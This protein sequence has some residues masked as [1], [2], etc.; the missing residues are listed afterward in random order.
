MMG[1][2]E[3]RWTSERLV[4]YPIINLQRN[5]GLESAWD[6]C[7][8][9]YHRMEPWDQGEFTALTKKTETTNHRK[10]PMVQRQDMGEYCWKVFILMILQGKIC[11]AVSRANGRNKGGILLPTDT[12]RKTG[13]NVADVIASKHPDPMSPAAEAFCQ[14]VKISTLIDVDIMV[15]IVEQVAKSMKGAAGPRGIDTVA[16]QD[17]NLWYDPLIQDLWEAITTIGRWMSS[18][19]PS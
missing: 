11:Q 15:D 19:Y 6:I 5:K 16:W 7:Q 18:T 4:V 3:L 13:K 10:Q 17:W 1:I 8:W 12:G 9:I 2:V 14:Y